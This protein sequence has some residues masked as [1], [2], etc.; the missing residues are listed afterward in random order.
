MFKTYIQYIYYISE[1]FT[2]Q[3]HAV[4]EAQVTQIIGNLPPFKSYYAALLKRKEKT[5]SNLPP[6]APQ[7]FSLSLWIIW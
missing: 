6:H 2:W 7:P 4:S 1:S 3:L 5:W